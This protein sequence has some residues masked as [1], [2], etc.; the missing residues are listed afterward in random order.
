[1]HHDTLPYLMFFSLSLAVAACSGEK[2]VGSGAAA[3]NVAGNYSVTVTNGPDGCNISS[4]HEGDVNANVPVA[5][6]QQGTAVTGTVGGIAGALFA[7]AVGTAEFHGTIGGDT[8][9]MTAYGT[10]GKTT[11]NCAYTNNA[12]LHL[13]ASGD[14]IQGTLRYQPSGNGN[15]DCASLTACTSVQNINGT[16]PPQSG[17]P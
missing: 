9:D 11:G 1:M 13:Q 12:V 6:M 7:L 14:F 17:T 3:V 5:L 4:W 10:I 15:P 8:V 16:R 2:S